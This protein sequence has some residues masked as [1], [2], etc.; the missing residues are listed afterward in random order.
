MFSRV[1][2]VLQFGSYFQSLITLR[3]GTA[4]FLFVIHHVMEQNTSVH[5]WQRTIWTQEDGGITQ[6]W[7]I[8]NPQS[9][10]FDQ[11]DYIRKIALSMVISM[12]HFTKS[13]FI[14]IF[15]FSYLWN[16]ES[17]LVFLD[18]LLLYSRF[19]DIFCKYSALE[20]GEVLGETIKQ[21]CSSVIKFVLEMFIYFFII[22]IWPPTLIP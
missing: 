7:V 15:F 8:L 22:S 1:L 13:I 9:I 20:M 11:Y 12:F 19:Q 3:S 5:A 18:F 21:N 10:S 17:C 16:V 2:D 14:F 4:F 6:V